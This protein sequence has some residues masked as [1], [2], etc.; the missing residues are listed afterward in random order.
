[1]REVSKQYPQPA[2]TR[3]FVGPEVMVT[4]G[5]VNARVGSRGEPGVV[6][7]SA[8]LVPGAS[9]SPVFD[10][11]GTVLGMAVRRTLGSASDDRPELMAGSVAVALPVVTRF[12]AA[13]GVTVTTAEPHA[14]LAIS[15]IGAR[16]ARAAAA[17][18]CWR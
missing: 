10:E 18:E 8:G 4:N 6:Q 1:M 9:G 15:E 12:L 7:L 13:Q 16:G 11:S 14:P 3:P 2:G 5:I 17:L